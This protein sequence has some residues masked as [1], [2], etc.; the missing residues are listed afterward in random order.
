MGAAPR[1][2]STSA[3][4][5][6]AP[7]LAAARRGDNAFATRKACKY[8]P[9]GNLAHLRSAACHARGRGFESRRSRSLH[10]GPPVGVAG[11]SRSIAWMSAAGSLIGLPPGHGVVPRVRGR[12]RPDRRRDGSLLAQVPRRVP[13]RPALGRGS[14]RHRGTRSASRRGRAIRRATSNGWRARKG[15][16]FRGTAPR[17]PVGCRR[18][19]RRR[20]DAA[21]CRGR[22]GVDLVDRRTGRGAGQRKAPKSTGRFSWKAFM[23]SCASGVSW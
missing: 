10:P 1:S 3:P 13:R 4:R 5:V 17:R 18:T 20:A 16:S 9:F 12:V 7:V 15:S 14:A 11:I 22:T 8:R 19:A 2:Q 6:A 21:G 23:P